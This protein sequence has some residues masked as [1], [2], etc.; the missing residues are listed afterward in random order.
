MLFLTV[1]L[2]PLE[3]FNSTV[4]DCMMGLWQEKTAEEEKEAKR[5]EIAA[6]VAAA[7]AAQE[8]DPAF[9][10]HKKMTHEGKENTFTIVLN[11]REH[12]IVLHMLQL[13]VVSPVQFL[14]FFAAFAS[15][16][17]TLCR[18]KS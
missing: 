3:T 4:R 7:K 18:V 8:K 6:R 16:F 17:L 1:Q 2:E 12:D 11:T 13:I 14:K 15:Q 9:N 10:Q 5:A